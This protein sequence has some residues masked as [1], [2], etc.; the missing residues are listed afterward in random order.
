MTCQSCQTHRVNATPLIRTAE[1]QRVELRFGASIEA[2]LRRLYTAEGMTQPEVA[3]HLGVSVR[4]VTRWMA[5][6]SIPTRDRR[7]V[8]PDRQSAA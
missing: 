4:S 5:A 1:Q 7:T 6:Y 3:Q 8:Q 2:L